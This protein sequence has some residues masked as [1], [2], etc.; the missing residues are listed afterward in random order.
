MCI[1]SFFNSCRK[2][3]YTH[4]NQLNTVASYKPLAPRIFGTA[5]L[6][7]RQHFTCGFTTTKIM[8]VIQYGLLL[9]GMA[10]LAKG[11]VSARGFP[12]SCGTVPPADSAI[13]CAKGKRCPPFTGVPRDH[14]PGSRAFP[15]VAPRSCF[16]VVF[17]PGGLG[18]L[19]YPLRYGR[20][21]S[22]NL[23]PPFFSSLHPPTIVP[24]PVLRELADGCVALEPPPPPPPLHQSPPLSP[25]TFP[26]CRSPSHSSTAHP[27]RSLQPCPLSPPLL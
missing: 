18:V 16:G 27:D 26:R 19:G 7:P 10:T 6:L 14:R 25:D 13:P 23:P 17:P 12:F 8:G 24:K 15:R 4:F 20:A 5:A 22:V 9:L 1:S 21:N 11:E 2:P 3:S